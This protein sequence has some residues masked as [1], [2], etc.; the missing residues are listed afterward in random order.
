MLPLLGIGKVYIANINIYILANSLFAYLY[1]SRK[2]Y[3]VVFL[4]FHNIF[5]LVLFSIPF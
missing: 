3:A 5:T 2:A 1:I 4:C